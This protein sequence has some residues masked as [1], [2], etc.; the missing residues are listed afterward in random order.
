MILQFLIGAS[1]SLAWDASPSPEV[2]KYYVYERSELQSQFVKVANT[3]AL[4]ITIPVKPMLS[5]QYAA[6]AADA[7]DAE[8]EFSNIVLYVKPA[9]LKIRQFQDGPLQ[10]YEITTSVYASMPWILEA[11]RNFTSWSNV[12]SGTAANDNLVITFN[13]PVNE[14]K[15]FY[16][17][18]KNTAQQMTLARSVAEMTIEELVNVEVKPTIR[19]QSVSAE[20]ATARP[21]AP[22]SYNTPTRW[23]RIKHAFR[24]RGY[25]KIDERKGGQRQMEG[26][27]KK[28]V[29][30]VV[31]P[32]MP[33]SVIKETE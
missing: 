5:M 24:Y 1:V 10:N 11:T 22:L 31:M 28:E 12:A 15:M 13:Q 17:L 19:S 7:S 4:T 16:R 32:P 8:S 2:V 29:K 23:Q 18:K 14:P 25:H 27:L 26:P 3:A 20:T 6:T 33:F 9:V 21:I 30:P